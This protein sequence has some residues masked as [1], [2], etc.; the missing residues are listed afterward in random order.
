[1]KI[2]FDKSFYGRKARFKCIYKRDN[3]V[4][5]FTRYYRDVTSNPELSSSGDWTAK[6][7]EEFFKSLA[8]YGKR[9]VHMIS[10]KIK[11]KQPYQVV[12]YMNLLEFESKRRKVLVEDECEES[13][14]W[15]VR[16]EEKQAEKRLIKEDEKA[17]ERE[18]TLEMKLLQAEEYYVYNFVNFAFFNNLLSGTM[19]HNACLEMHRKMI[20]W[21]FYLVTELCHY[22]EEYQRMVNKHPNLITRDCLKRFLKYKGIEGLDV[23]ELDQNELNQNESDR[24]ES[25]R[26]ELNR[27]ELDQNE[28]NQNEL[29]R[30]ESDRNESDQYGLDP[31]E[32]NQDSQ[33]QDSQNQDI[34]NQD[35]QNQ[36][37]QN[38]DIQIQD[39]HTFELNSNNFTLAVDKLAEMKDLKNPYTQ[40]PS[41]DRVISSKKIEMKKEIEERDRSL[42]DKF[43]TEYEEKVQ[44]R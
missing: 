28:L 18:K 7:K 19:N 4:K 27:N 30:N 8:R 12:T 38:Q 34:Q 2:F 13:S 37:I 5:Q 21:I 11:T 6:E 16:W 31:N 23:N 3:L 43:D 41:L 26:N 24:N 32:L 1:M 35:I 22:H 10:D 44:M 25:D 29:N 15:Q 36:D 33:N 40:R 17:I 42:M 39:D 9:N 14:E 20:D